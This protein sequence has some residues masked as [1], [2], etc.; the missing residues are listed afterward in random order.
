[1]TSK[2][3]DPYF[4]PGAPPPP[5]PLL[6]SQTDLYSTVHQTSLLAEEELLPADDSTSRRRSY[7]RSAVH[8][9]Y[10]KPDKLKFPSKTKNGS[11]PADVASESSATSDTSPESSSDESQSSESEEDQIRKPDGEAGRPRSGGY[12]LE[13]ELKWHPSDF[14]KLKVQSIYQK[15]W[16]R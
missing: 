7:H 3:V 6:T 5:I 9:P 14:K 4:D 16:N 1:M 10:K 2:P 8:F 11:I 12:N 15:P 13:S